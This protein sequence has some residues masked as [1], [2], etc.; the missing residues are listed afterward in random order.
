MWAVYGAHILPPGH[1][2]WMLS[3]RIGPD[4]VQHWLGHTFFKRTAWSWPPGLN[5]GWGME[6]SSSIFCADA[7]PLLAFLFKALDP[8]AEVG[9]YW[10]L[11]LYACGAPQAVLAWRLIGPG[12][13]ALLHRMGGH[14]AL[15]GQF[16]V[17]AGLWLCLTRGAGWRRLASW[18]VLLLA[19]ALIHAHLLVIVAGL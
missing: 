16:V 19:T 4:P 6:L 9:Q 8:L 18:T 13:A 11:W 17:L 15:G 10:G 5:P 14:L 12:T 2:G 3:G 1:A 7:I